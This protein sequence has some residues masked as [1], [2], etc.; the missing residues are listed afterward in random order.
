[1]LRKVMTAVKASRL[2]TGA[3]GAAVG[4]LGLSAVWP[5]LSVL[6]ADS[7][8]C[9][10]VNPAQGWIGL[11]LH[12][13][14]ASAACPEGS[15]APGPAL[16]TAVGFSVVVSLS[17]LIAGLTSIAFGV[18]FGIAIRRALRRA[19]GW[20]RRRLRPAL[21]GGLVRPAPVPVP[22]RVPGRRVQRSHSPRQL[23]GPPT[24]C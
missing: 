8:L 17:V 5:G 13:L 2:I 4:V 23:R 12:L 9:L 3:V 22:V 6:S 10:Q 7:G 20:W 11:N 15:F 16:A 14:M 19:R 18:G 1:M 21:L 24:S